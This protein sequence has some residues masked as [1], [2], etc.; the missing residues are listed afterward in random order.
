MFR[1]T[2]QMAILPGMVD[3]SAS[4]SIDDKPA[5]RAV[6]EEGWRDQVPEADFFSSQP[7]VDVLLRVI[8]PEAT[9]KLCACFGGLS[10]E[11]GL[12]PSKEIVDA[13]GVDAAVKLRDAW[14]KGH[15][16]VPRRATSAAGR[17]E[18]IRK[19]D[20]AGKTRQEIAILVGVSERQVY[21]V[22]AG[23]PTGRVSGT[24]NSGRLPLKFA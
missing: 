8:G 24:G 5:L 9:E 12:G 20:A 14:G 6:V 3:R 4:S 7:S 10:R 13:I 23:R 2:G 11:I 17:H 15:L 1:G 22:L 21:N 19:L 16:Y 18:H